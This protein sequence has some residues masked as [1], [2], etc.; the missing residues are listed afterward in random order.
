MFLKIQKDML[1]N[2]EILKH[3]IKKRFIEYYNY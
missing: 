1:L 3:N 2:I